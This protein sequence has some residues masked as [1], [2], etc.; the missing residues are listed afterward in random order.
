MAAIAVGSVLSARSLHRPHGHAST[1]NLRTLATLQ[2]GLKICIER[3]GD[4]YRGL[5]ALLPAFGVHWLDV[6]R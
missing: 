6:R 5:G 2:D 3:S 1:S 4:A